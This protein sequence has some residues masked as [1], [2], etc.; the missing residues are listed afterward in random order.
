MALERFSGRLGIEGEDA[1]KSLVYL[2]V[3]VG[4]PIMGISLYGAALEHN[5]HPFFLV[6]TRGLKIASEIAAI[7]ACGFAL[8]HAILAGHNP[9]TGRK[10]N[11]I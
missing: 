5:A 7:P 10:K 11:N 8:W 4:L 2:I 1:R 6:T 9:E 3:T